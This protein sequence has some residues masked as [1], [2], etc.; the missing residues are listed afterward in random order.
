MC[1]PAVAQE[2][3]A[4]RPKAAPIPFKFQSEIYARKNN[5]GRLKDM[6][7]DG[8]L[9]ARKPDKDFGTS[10]LKGNYTQAT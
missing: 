3:R 10:R 2:I 5:V 9:A 1:T 7:A 6:P 4:R 8:T